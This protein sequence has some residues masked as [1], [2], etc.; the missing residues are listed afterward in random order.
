MIALPRVYPILDTVAFERCE[1]GLVAAAR[2]MLE[3]GAGILQ[4]RHKGHWSRAI[5]TE[6][7]EIVRLCH[8]YGVT[9]VVNDRADIAMLLDAGLHVG[10]DDLP[11]AD[12]RRLIG[13][14][15]MLGLSTHN[16]EQLAVAV[17]QPVDYIAIGPLFA[18]VSK[19]NPDPVVGP[20]QFRQWR[21]MVEVPVVAIGGITRMNASKAWGAGADSVAVIGDLLPPICN[22][23]NLKE[24]I[25]EWHRPQ[26]R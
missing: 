10:Q 20:E 6:A 3:G 8:E 5:F 21:K 9:A 16:A 13:K 14:S 2:A 18:T 22:E 23:Q 19:E 24:R 26:S 7:E 12:A 11:A 4:I 1:C 25:Q 17:K 15:R